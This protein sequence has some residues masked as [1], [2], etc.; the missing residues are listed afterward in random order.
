MSIKCTFTG[1]EPSPKG[2]GFC[3]RNEKENAVRIG[4]NEKLWIVKNGKWLILNNF[5]LK[6]KD[7]S[8]NDLVYFIDTK[9]N[10][11]ICGIKCNSKSVPIEIRLNNSDM[12]YECLE[13]SNFSL[14]KCNIEKYYYQVKLDKYYCKTLFFTECNNNE[15]F[16]NLNKKGILLDI[17]LENNRKNDKCMNINDIMNMKINQNIIFA[18]FDRNL[19]ESLLNIESRKIYNIINLVKKCNL[20][21]YIIKLSENEFKISMYGEE[22]TGIYP[23]DINYSDVNDDVQRWYPLKNGYLPASYSNK[24]KKKK[25]HISEFPKKTLIGSRGCFIMYNKLNINDKIYYL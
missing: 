23:F 18:F 17:W 19:D 21:G 8:I 15:Y 16:H 3:A 24:L 6:E 4:N 5:T 14:N 1:S 7:V 11:Q 25:M 10:I 2:L 13:N 9:K 20:L 12:F 22:T